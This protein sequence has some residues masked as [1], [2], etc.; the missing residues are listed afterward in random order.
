MKCQ[1]CG[2]ETNLPFTCPYCGGQFCSEHRLPEN[3]LC[4]RIN[5]ARS[6]RQQQV[7]TPQSYN[8][9]QY[10]YNLGPSSQRKHHIT[11]SPK[12]VKHLTVAAAL[13][14][15]HWFLHRILW[16]LFRRLLLHLDFDI[17][18]GICS[19]FDGFHVDP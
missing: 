18:G 12:E 8:S 14:S 16:D 11:S 9:Y 7:M 13:I 17:N 15:R 4:P 5:F 1:V 3:H 6:Q 2:Q 10:S 19:N